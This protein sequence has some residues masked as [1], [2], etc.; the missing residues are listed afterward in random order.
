MLSPYTFFYISEKNS[1]QIM[2]KCQEIIGAER[3]LTIINYLYHEETKGTE[4]EKK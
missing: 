2:A 3:I 1:I 4:E